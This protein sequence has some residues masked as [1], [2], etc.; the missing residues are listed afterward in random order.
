MHQLL[1][2]PDLE[3]KPGESQDPEPSWGIPLPNDIRV[4][5]VSLLAEPKQDD[6]RDSPR[7]ALVFVYSPDTGSSEC[8]YLVF[9][10]Q[11]FRNRVSTLNSTPDPYVARRPFYVMAHTILRASLKQD[12]SIGPVTSIFIAGANFKFDLIR[13]KRKRSESVNDN[14]E[15]LITLGVNHTP[16][17]IYGLSVFKSGK[18]I[19]APLSKFQVS[20]YQTSDLLLSGCVTTT[21]QIQVV[22]IVWNIE[23]L[24]GEILSWSVPSFIAP[25]TDPLNTCK[26]DISNM[27]NTCLK[28][29]DTKQPKGLRHPFNVCKDDGC[30]NQ[31]E[32]L[33]L[34]RLCEVGSISD[35]AFQSTSGSQFD[36]S[37]GLVPES[38]FGSVLRCGQNSQK[39]RRSQIG[40]VES[41]LFS[42]NILDMNT[43][44]QSVF[45]I[46]PPAFVISLYAL[47]LEEASI[48]MDN[49]SNTSSTTLRERNDRLKVR[50]F[51]T[52][53]RF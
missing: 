13:T 52:F 33:V 49:V 10:L 23:L 47:F 30:R 40:G 3:W 43:Y 11:V 41:K 39:F 44:S 36:I 1:D 9:R 42:S 2:T 34:G 12:R 37:L 26:M 38:S 7:R 51:Q 6:T 25:P 24:N 27:Y 15:F 31:M 32:Y 21:Q 48:R 29:A 53:E 28:P 16:G 19:I 18:T 46:T 45:M 8:G 17:G 22:S 5:N 50:D 14:D 4:S 35:W 20:K